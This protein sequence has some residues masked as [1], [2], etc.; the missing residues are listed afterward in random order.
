[1]PGLRRKKLF[2]CI[3]VS[4][5]TAS[6]VLSVSIQGDTKN[7]VPDTDIAGIQKKD[8][9]ISNS[10]GQKIT[11]SGAYDEIPV[12]ILMKKQKTLPDKATQSVLSGAGASAGSSAVTS[13]GSSA[14][15][16]AVESNGGKTERR[17][18]FIGAIS[19]KMPAWKIAELSKMPE[20]EKIYYDEIVA[21]PL[22]PSHG[23]ITVATTGTDAIGANYAWDSG[24]TGTGIKLA[25]IDT[26]INYNHPDL[27]GG[28]GT[29]KKVA[30]GYDF[31]NNDANPMDD[32]GHGTHVAGTAAANG[33]IKGVAPDATLY[34]VKVLNSA[35]S[36]TT[37]NVIA[38]IDWS[39]AHG[40]D[41]ISM[42]LGSS[43]QPTDE[44]TDI[45]N[46]V[47]DAAVD[48]G[49][50]VVVAAGNS[51]PGTNTISSP[52]SSRKVITVGASD[53]SS[54]ATISDD[55]IASFSDRG[56]SAFGRLDPDVVAPGVT[57][58]STSY[59]GSYTNKSGTSMSTPHVSG[60]AALLLQKNPALSPA[61]VRAIL[62]H[63]SSNLTSSHVFEKGAGIINLTNAF[64]YN[65]SANIN[66]DDRWEESVI[67]T[68]STIGKLTLNNT[69]TY[70]VNFTFSIEAM[71]DLEGDNSIPVS[72]FSVPAYEMISAGSSKTI[73]LTFTSPTDTK[74]G[75]YG[76]TLIVSNSTAGT[77][78]I[79]VVIT[80]PLM[81]GG[82]IQGSV[83]NAYSYFSDYDGDW[84]YYKLKSPNS[85]KMSIFLNWTDTSDDLDLYLYA[86]NGIQVNV[87]GSGLGTISE[88]VSLSNTVYDEYWAAVHAYSLSGSGSYFLNVS[89]P[90]GTKGN[91]EV[92]PASWQGV[93]LSNEI[94]NISFSITNDASAKTN[95][96]LTVKKLTGGR[97]N[98]SSGT[99]A[100]TGSSYLPVWTAEA[101]GS[102][103]NNTRYMNATL[104]WVNP[105]ND[106][107]LM[108][109]YYNGAQ[110]ATTRFESAHNNPQ[111]GR[112]WE[113]LEN[114]DIQH[115]L[116]NYP[117]FGIAIKNAGSSESYNLTINF[118]DTSSWSGA[119]V[120]ES[121]ISL[122]SL[123]TRQVNVT[124]NGP[125]INQNITDLIFSV[126]DSTEDFAS[127]PIRINLLDV[128]SPTAI[129]NP[130][131]YP[132]GYTA[133]KNGTIIT[134]NASISDNY[135]VR[136]AS[137]NASQ[138]NSSLGNVALSYSNGFWSNS[139]VIVAAP[140]GTYSL[141][142]TAY[143][144]A[145]NMNNTS[146]VTV[147]VDNT[148]PLVSINP[149]TYARGSAAKN[150]S[151]IVFNIS[152]SD[153]VAGGTSSGLK[154]ASL[155]VSIINNT[156]LVTLTNQSSF[157][158]S[159]AVFDKF[160]NDG[161]HLMNVTFSDFA[162]NTNSSQQA[163]ITID[164]TPPSVTGISASPSILNRTGYT[165]ITANIT[166]PDINPD[167]VSVH[168]EYPDGSLSDYN[169][170]TGGGLFYYNFTDTAQYGRFTA[171]VSA[172]DTTGNTNQTRQIQF[173]TAFLTINTSV[174]TYSNNETLIL[175]PVS[176]STLRLS[177]N[178]TNTGSINI[179]QSKV[180]VT[181]N[182]LSITNPG[183]YVLVNASPVIEDNL[184]YAVISINYTDAEISSYVE[185]SL[186]L[187][188][189]NTTSTDWDKLSG[190]GS[191]PYVNDAGV[192][193]VNNFVWANLTRLSE[194]AVSGD[195]YVQPA[196]QQAASSGGGGGGGGG[197]ASAENFSN[198]EVKEKY[199]LHI[200]K[201]KTTSYAFRNLSNP[202]IFVNI[203]GNVSAGEV[204]TA[205]EVLKNTSALVKMPVPGTVYKNINIWVGT[206]GFAVPRNIREAI[207]RFSVRNEW[208]SGRFAPGDVSLYQYYDGE[209]NRLETWQAG[210]NNDNTSFEARTVRFSPFAI[211][212]DG[213]SG[214]MQAADKRYSPV[215]P[216]S[217]MAVAEASATP[218][219]TPGFGLLQA[220]AMIIAMYFFV[221]KRG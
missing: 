190:A 67:P 42:S 70:A 132:S 30:D 33:S 63:T 161:N 210:K 55:T 114:V 119:S 216:G 80:I 27:G 121:S 22:E 25:I 99:V 167:E 84:I 13:A 159:S 187:Y 79:P 183:I 113:K 186:R 10:L 74:P 34:A 202:I 196:Q 197:G 31:V 128:T 68:F 171:T 145:G 66:G 2:I 182:S 112:A 220:V 205:V 48:Q 178:I 36:G 136:N 203:T 100:G 212:A 130:T 32:Q 18:D 179:T 218:A 193:T 129:A 104:Q 12:I 52:G 37:S 89:Y 166:S 169:M 9:K 20:V 206:S 53:D 199:D 86:P 152:A 138:I 200:F 109:E 24:Y 85:T 16:S 28:F 39:I 195:L 137:I 97:S 76:T 204:N 133:A 153:P 1:M 75:I 3:V 110:W 73:D 125:L 142:I 184:S 69:N 173:I 54:T 81:N 106:L 141:N 154:N 177:T 108:L 7:H 198:I 15:V 43:S 64:T 150:N 21:L 174:I 45:L 213:G 8:L 60:A 180:N 59:T 176:N 19:A 50:V 49:I 140:D 124:I 14:V 156:G 122:G 146:Q 164:N 57:I 221:R 105:S 155:N 103:L 71:T 207:I 91:L 215:T 26:G 168:V 158:N 126:W 72:S 38:G 116:K 90:A 107:D 17:Y 61:Q 115:Y 185:S 87:S 217:T 147:V 139:S 82:S 144:D 58:N 23:N 117:A 189:W 163:N 127:V 44:F 78:R 11:S 214:G 92:S 93:I 123:Q 29:G 95:I 192:D 102:D 188:R 88:K 6:V 118:T 172:N 162:G 40:A 77:L 35:G 83:N 149:V 120:N 201:D 209:W 143:D 131:G 56:P 135:G 96:N 101:N 148:P 151:N 175:A 62:M 157:W 47:S 4:L 194:F 211:T 98:F 134:L 46:I 51:G 5:V 191:Y 181:S 165:N 160:I 41:V 94:K 65:I 111:L 219:S 208:L 170:S